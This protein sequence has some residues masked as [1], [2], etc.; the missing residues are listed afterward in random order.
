VTGG[1]RAGASVPVSGDLGGASGPRDGGGASVWRDLSGASGS[2][3]RGSAS[4]VMVALIGVIVSTTAG[5]LVLAGVVRS[6]HQARLGADLSAVAGALQLRDGATA[7][8]SCAEAA[9]IAAANGTSLQ[10][11][12]VSGSDVT[13]VVAASSSMWPEPATAKARAGPE[14]SV[15]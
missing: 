10:A 1:S 9:R 6:S 4:V 5:V 8:A 3:D 14:T 13:V 15:T 11:C 2:R 12:S 7:S